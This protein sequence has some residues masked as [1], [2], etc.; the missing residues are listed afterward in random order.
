[1]KKEQYITN[2]KYRII[3]TLINVS[4]LTLDDIKEKNKIDIIKI[5]NVCVLE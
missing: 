4:N 2:I 1:V 5:N 3:I